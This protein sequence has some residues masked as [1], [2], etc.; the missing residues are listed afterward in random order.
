MCF[1]IFGVGVVVIVMVLMVGF[2]YVLFYLCSDLVYV[3]LFL[4]LCCVIYFKGVNIYGFIMGYILGFVLC[5]GGG[6]DKIG[7]F[8]FIKYLFYDEVKGQLF[9]FCIL[10]MIVLFVIIV[11]VLYLMKFLFEREIILLKYDFLNCFNKYDFDKLLGDEKGQLKYVMKEKGDYNKSFEV[12][13][14]CDI[15]I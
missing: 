1:V 11:V 14:E 3:I 9:F 13:E 8:L 6:E 4:Q 15:K 12:N 2:I 10:F 5:V 7:F